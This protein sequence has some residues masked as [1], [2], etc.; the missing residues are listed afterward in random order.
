M[1][2]LACDS[3]ALIKNFLNCS[4]VT[5]GVLGDFSSSINKMQET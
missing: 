3:V 1:R 2:N 5:L 4:F